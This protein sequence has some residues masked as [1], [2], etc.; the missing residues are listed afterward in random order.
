MFCVSCRIVSL[1]Y[2][3]R[4]GLSS[5]NW[6]CSLQVA[7]D[8]WETQAGHMRCEFTEPR[9][10][11][12]SDFMAEDWRAP[13]FLRKTFFVSAHSVWFCSSASHTFI[14]HLCC[15]GQAEWTH[16]SPQAS[17][18][19]VGGPLWQCVGVRWRGGTLRAAAGDCDVRAQQPG[20]EPAWR[21]QILRGLRGRW[22]RGPG[23]QHEDR[24]GA[25][26]GRRRHRL[27]GRITQT[28]L[29]LEHNLFIHLTLAASWKKFSRISYQKA[30]L[31]KTGRYNG[32]LWRA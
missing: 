4:K 27:G 22:E 30:T 5:D 9:M 18:P 17:R 14:Y 28:T 8:S 23:W 11:N 3:W 31:V 19:P 7:K 13:S 20:R 29:P 15:P 32:E 26:W 21:S 16:P 12:S 2:K 25:I 6:R 10:R 24:H 1:A